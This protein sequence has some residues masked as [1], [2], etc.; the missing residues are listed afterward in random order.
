M[1][2]ASASPRSAPRHPPASRLASSRQVLRRS[3]TPLE[4]RQ[5]A[6]ILPLVEGQHFL[7]V[8]LL[9][10]NAVAMEALPLFLDRLADPV[11]AIGECRGGPSKCAGSAVP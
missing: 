9:L 2:Q 8:T 6:R 1:A 4:R 7:L 11:T 5:A 10:C 3:G